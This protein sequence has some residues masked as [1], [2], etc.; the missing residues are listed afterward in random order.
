MP[1]A[2]PVYP[3]YK[4]ENSNNAS[5]RRKPAQKDTFLII[6]SNFESYYK[7]LSNINHKRSKKNELS[8]VKQNIHLLQLFLIVATV[9]VISKTKAIQKKEVLVYDMI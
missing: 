1:S 9:G 2:L 6:N 4:N 8:K 7:P 3:I 5:E